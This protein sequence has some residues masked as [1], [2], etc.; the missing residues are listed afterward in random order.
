MYIYIYIYSTICWVMSLV[1]MA[2]GLGFLVMDLGSR[3]QGEENLG[4]HGAYV[5]LDKVLGSYKAVGERVSQRLRIWG[6]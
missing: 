2:M 4:L 6:L 5:L 1:F 3:G